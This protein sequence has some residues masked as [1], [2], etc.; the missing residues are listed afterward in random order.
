MHFSVMA[1]T[2]HV[3]APVHPLSGSLVRDVH[4]Y[5][6]SL[7]MQGPFGCACNVLT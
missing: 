6:A 3:E 4:W 7:L 1:C 2:L 5:Q